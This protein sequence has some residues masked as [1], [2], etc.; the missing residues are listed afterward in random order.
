M[1]A[2]V[3]LDHRRNPGENTGNNRALHDNVNSRAVA[4]QTKESSAVY[5]AR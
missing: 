3:R 2:P 5:K 1:D 4:K